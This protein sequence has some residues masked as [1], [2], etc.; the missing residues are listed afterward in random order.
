VVGLLNVDVGFE[1]VAGRAGTAGVVDE[2]GAVVDDVVGRFAG[3]LAGAAV[4]AAAPP[5]SQ[6]FGGEG[7]F[8]RTSQMGSSGSSGSLRTESDSKSG[9][10]LRLGPSLLPELSMFPQ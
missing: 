7:M 2:D 8:L 3:V 6:G 4:A 1:S 5:R 9:G 10:R